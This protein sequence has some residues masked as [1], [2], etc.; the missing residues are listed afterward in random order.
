MRAL[1][2]VI[3]AALAL[4]GNAE[5]TGVFTTFTTPNAVLGGMSPSGTYSVAITQDFTGI[6]CVR[7]TRATGD[8]ES[9][10]TL[11][12]C[13]GI[14]EAG[15]L[16]GSVPID[17]GS[18][19]GGHDSAALV[20]I[21]ASDPEVLPSIDGFDNAQLRG[22]SGDDNAAVGIAI[23]ADQSSAKAILWTRGEGTVELPV[24]SGNSAANRISPDGSVVVGWADEPQFG[25]RRAVIWQDRVP[26]Y[27]KDAQDRD[28]GEAQ[29]V[30][31]NN[32]F[33]VGTGYQTDDGQFV[34]WRWD[35][36]SGDVT[37]IPGMAFAGAVTDD[38]RVVTGDTGFL[39]NRL[40]VVWTQ[41]E[42]TATLP[43][44]LAARDIP[45][46]AG[47]VILSGVL[48][49][50]SR[51]G[52]I[53]GGC[54][55][56]D[57]ND[58]SL[59]S[60][61]I[62]G[63]DEPRDALFRS[64]FEP[65]VENPVVDSG[66]ETTTVSGGTNPNWEGLDTNPSATS[67]DSG[68]P[69]CF[70]SAAFGGIAPHSGLWSVFF[71]G[72]LNGEAETQ[73]FSQS[74]VLPADVPLYLNYW[75]LAAQLPDAGT[76][77]VSVDGQTVQSTDLA[78]LPAADLDFAPQSADIGAFADGAAHTIRVVYSYPGGQNDGFIFID[79]VTVAASP[80]GAASARPHGGPA[81]IAHLLV[82]K[83]TR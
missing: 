73:D 35:A 5:A 47:W 21:G 64:D 15:T 9:I 54:C 48:N 1:P 26:T 45:K 8:E 39:A 61:V 49:G 13:M 17:G 83:R 50:I 6:R 24:D 31:A 10:L 18:S 43:D 74:V 25:A 32:R 34:A 58:F 81:G 22:V 77:I 60:F 57:F 52:S 63:V 62:S 55:G 11:N 44:Y 33:V 72:W 82:R 29:A 16:A 27:P 19:G 56:P 40:L 3:L 42:G 12:S 66:F 46:P 51:D 4:G 23:S 38:G 59:H 2:I 30:S 70:Y 37:P 7:F 41:G 71:G 68:P 53:I 78:T 67:P 69:T 14:N 36:E 76:L 65:V 75:R 20:A 80:L 79:D 28:I